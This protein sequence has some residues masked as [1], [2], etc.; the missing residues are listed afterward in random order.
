MLFDLQS[1]RRRTAVKIIYLLLAV[2]MAG[3]LV[4]F[5]VGAGNGNGGFL[6]SLTGN[7]SGGTSAQSSAVTKA[8]KTAEKQVAATPNSA[9]AWRSL[10]QARY[11]VAGSGS[12]YNTT[13]GQFNA[14]GKAELTKVIAAWTKYASLVK[15]TPDQTSI[16]LAA[17]AY[18][19]T[20]DWSGATIVWQDFIQTDPGAGKGYECLA[21][22][23]YAAK[24]TNLGNEAAAKATSLTPKLDRLQM[25]QSFDSAKTSQTTA[26]TDAA[27]ACA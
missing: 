19:A 27:A 3:G 26:Q 8:L 20:G 14:A 16:L 18:S 15:G 7:G 5:G 17:R 22:T 4:L 1:R 2:L 12:N 10:M 13:S 21:L 23:A 9:S 11:D 24:K 6:N 25:K